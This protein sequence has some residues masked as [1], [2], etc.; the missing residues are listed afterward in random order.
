M[1]C[2]TN[3]SSLTFILTSLS[4]SYHYTTHRSKY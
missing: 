2:T 1:I 4:R 3:N